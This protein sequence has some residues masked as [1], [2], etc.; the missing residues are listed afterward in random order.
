M[1]D[2]IRRSAPTVRLL[3][4]A[5][6]L[7]GCL[8]CGD[9]PEAPTATFTYQYEADQR[10]VS[11][12]ATGS[13]SVAGTATPAGPSDAK[14][15]YLWN[16][17]D[18]NSWD[19]T[20]AVPNECRPEKDPKTKHTYTKPGRYTVLLVVSDENRSTAIRSREI[21]VANQRP[22]AGFTGPSRADVTDRVVFNGCEASKDDSAVVKWEFRFGDGQTQGPSPDCRAGHT[23]TMLGDLRVTL[24]VTDDDDV[25]SEPFEQFIHIGRKADTTK[26]TVTITTPTEGKAVSGMVHIEASASDPEDNNPRV[27]F[28]I[29]GAFKHETNVRPYTYNWDSSSPPV[30]DGPHKIQATA[31]D[32]SSNCT[33]SDPVTVQVTNP[34]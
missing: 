6:V 26:P 22:S 25:S 21:H 18:G 5:L 33:D 28:Y 20:C 17:G 30:P 1:G 29:D 14:L 32:D 23:Y 19:G 13:R 4:P 15:D 24:I 34:R 27:Q 16:F 2:R 10:T 9:L 8:C 31:C 11:F 7:A 12:D 3:F